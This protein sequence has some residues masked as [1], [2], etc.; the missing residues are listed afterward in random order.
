MK[1][2]KKIIFSFL[3]L[4]MMIGSI[5][6]SSC[7]SDNDQSNSS[8]EDSGASVVTPA[9]GVSIRSADTTTKIRKSETGKG[10][11]NYQLSYDVVKNEYESYQLLLSSD[12]DVS[13]YYLTA[14]DLK[15]GNNTLSKN[16]FEVYM[17]RYVPAL[18]ERDITTYG[19]GEY[20]DAL[21]PIDVAKDAGELTIEANENSALWITVYV[22]KDTVAGLYKGNFEL[23]IGT[24]TYQVPV[25]VNVNDY[26]LTDERNAV[27]HFAYRYRFV[28][29]GEMDYTTE[30]MQTY[31]DFFADYRLSLGNPVVDNPNDDG[32][33]F[34][35]F[36]YDHWDEMTSYTFM[37]LWGEGPT[38]NLGGVKWT[39]VKNQIMAVA[40]LSTPE[41]NLLDKGLLYYI[42]EPQWADPT[43]PTYAP[44]ENFLEKL[45]K[46]TTDLQDLVAEMDADTTG[47]F[48]N[49][50]KIPNWKDE[51]ININNIV[52][53]DLIKQV[54]GRLNDA[55]IQR[56]LSAV[57]ILCPKW[58][59]CE[60]SQFAPLVET[61]QKEYGIKIWWYGCTDPNGPFASYHIAETNLLNARTITWLQSMYEIEGN[62][63]WD[64]AG[65]QYYVGTQDSNPDI[66][67]FPYRTP[68]PYRTDVAGDG[69]IC[70]PG[71]KY[72][73]ETPLPSIR[74]M[75]IRDGNEDYELLRDLK[76][77]INGS[78]NK[79]L[80][81][82]KEIQRLC[83]SL[84][85]NGSMLYAEGEANLDFNGIR[86]ELIDS[87]VSFNDGTNFG[88]SSISKVNNKA[89]VKLTADS[90]KYKVS[91]NNKELTL[92][93]DGLYTVEL[94]LTDDG[95]FTF[96]L[97]NKSSGAKIE[98]SR[99]I[100]TAVTKLM[101]FDGLTTVPSKGITLKSGDSCE[102]NKDANKT[103]AQN[104]KFTVHSK[105]TGTAV[106][107]NAYAPKFTMSTDLF[108]FTKFEDAVLIHLDI[109]NLKDYQD[110]IIIS[111]VSGDTVFECKQIVLNP[112]FNSVVIPLKNQG[113]SNLA[114]V[115]GIEFKFVNRG[116][117][118]NPMHHV[119]CFDNM[120]V[121]TKGE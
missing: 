26:T 13:S 92:G 121:T 60:D 118:A 102:I 86:A 68:G 100:G 54:A 79:K 27:T 51:I 66:Y 1:S 4:T 7:F 82:K 109:Y 106:V 62:L 30:M 114:S 25:N 103:S 58:K 45:D 107:D 28:G 39:N 83:D 46:L 98:K 119:V 94:P 5:T 71:A 120:Y 41:K 38:G 50:K 104:L 80:D 21:I 108:G 112:G 16:N 61:L 72:G 14:S 110:R 11:T 31:Y 65:S 73:L 74:L 37:P 36:V 22:P 49:F 12:K 93:S 59:N 29:M 111:L 91:Y 42:D 95:Y 105:I 24:E 6:L 101:D 57:N 23:K 35:K 44:I 69:Y 43:G 56:F 52:P 17:Q 33:E 9:G 81:A 117:K 97:E 67:E 90:S 40:A 48:T 85:Y 2:I 64:V 75:S 96:V 20:P 76:N 47:R 89:T 53:I 88:V 84:Y 34:A 113:I 32:T 115:D 77:K 19:A 99:Y 15:C 8:K 63:Y 116:S 78:S 10:S 70:Y 87:L 18:S 3:T 55:D